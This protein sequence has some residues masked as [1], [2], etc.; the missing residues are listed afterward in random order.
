[1]FGDYREMDEFNNCSHKSLTSSERKSPLLGIDSHA[2]DLR[3]SET[4]Q[5]M[6]DGDYCSEQFYVPSLT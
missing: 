1:M 3:R 6:Q 5:T 2:D 4:R